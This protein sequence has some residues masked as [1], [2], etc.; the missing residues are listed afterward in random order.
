MV[1]TSGLKLLG[2]VRLVRAVLPWVLASFAALLLRRELA[3]PP[4]DSAVVPPPAST[5]PEKQ[6]K[7]EIVYEPWEQV[8][9]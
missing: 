9:T 8:S 5:E 7:E 6:Q 4:R 2:S 1:R 3:P